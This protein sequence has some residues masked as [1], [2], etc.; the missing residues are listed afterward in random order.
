MEQDKKQEL[1]RLA[2]QLLELKSKAEPVPAGQG[3]EPGAAGLDAASAEAAS[4]EAVRSPA[5]EGIVVDQIQDLLDANGELHVGHVEILNLEGIRQK[6]SKGSRL[7][8]DGLEAVTQRSI[9]RHLSERDTFTKCGDDYLIAFAELDESV[10]RQTSERILNDVTEWLSGRDDAE[11]TKVETFV[12][13]ISAEELD[14]A[15]QNLDA[16]V[17]AVTSAKLLNELRQECESGQAAGR[18]EVLS[19]NVQFKFRPIWHVGRK[20][21]STFQCL[22]VWSSRSGKSLTG[23]RVLAADADA[24]LLI[25]MDLRVLQEAGH[26][27]RIQQELGH[28][29]LI[30]ATVHFSTLNRLHYQQRYMAALLDIPKRDRNLLVLEVT[31]LPDGTPRGRLLDASLALKAYSRARIVMIPCDRLNEVSM[32]AEANFLAVGFD[33]QGRAASETVL[34][35]RLNAFAAAAA[36]YRLKP[37]VHGLS[38]LS[39][40]TAA[41]C[42]GFDYIDGEAIAPLMDAPSGLTAFDEATPYKRLIGA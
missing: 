17:A 25:D 31:G 24:D 35:A 16:V 40:T 39:L 32:I 18:A 10:A 5:S 38:S 29:Q 12:T 28:T 14:D 11:N 27:L 13:T 23:D 30:S 34:M 19:P 20:V 26:A 3:E 36:N 7:L 22:P 21:I 37:F 1:E 8:L 15:G 6:A 2:S 33:L 4:D 42:A 41:V 9:S